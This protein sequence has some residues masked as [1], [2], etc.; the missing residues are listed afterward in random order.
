MI[1]DKKHPGPND[2][3]LDVLPNG[4]ER[5]Y[6]PRTDGG[7][8]WMKFPLVEHIRDFG[9]K[10]VYKNC[11]EWCSGS[12]PMGFYVLDQ[13]L[14]DNLVLADKYD[15]AISDCKLTI[16]NNKLEDS[17]VAYQCDRVQD[18]PQSEPWDLVISNP[19]HCWDVT[20]NMSSEDEKKAEYLNRVLLDKNL[21]THTEFF[22]NV[23]ERL[24][25]DG[26]M[27]IIEAQHNFVEENGYLY[28]DA[29]FELIGNYYFGHLD[30][31]A[32]G[33]KFDYKVQEDFTWNTLHL[34]KKD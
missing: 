3:N 11:Y 23:G 16:E 26:E 6:H 34:I 21:K 9:K 32:G 13:G 19:P 31:V 24:A 10:D 15:L 1:L 18:I 17:V 29:G 33:F 25:Q 12:G 2:L 5:Y 4:L 14:V 8:E 20:P 30:A 22:N 7:G 27:F 28:E